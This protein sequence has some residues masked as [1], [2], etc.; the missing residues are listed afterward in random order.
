MAL[1]VLLDRDRP[2]YVV[3][4]VLAIP[5]PT[6]MEIVKDARTFSGYKYPGVVL[7]DVPI[8]G[9]ALQI[10]KTGQAAFFT[11]LAN[12]HGKMYVSGRIH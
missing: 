8:L 3:L 2:Q 7:G 9:N 6:I 5:V 10:P 4:A 1:E 12:Q 11:K